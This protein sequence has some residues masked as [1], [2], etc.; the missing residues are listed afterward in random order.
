SRLVPQNFD[1]LYRMAC[2]YYD[3]KMME[4]SGEFYHKA[5]LIKENDPDVLLALG[6][7]EVFK[8]NYSGARKLYD[9]SL[10]KNGDPKII[11]NNLSAVAQ[12]LGFLDLAIEHGNNAVQLDPF[13][14]L[15]LVNLG[16]T[17]CEKREY[18][19]AFENLFKA[20]KLDEKDK[21]I[22]MNLGNLF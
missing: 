15:P 10:K 8:C 3:L 12:T 16:C 13:Y 20:A 7:I 6:N 22:Y 17:Y 5:G 1:P 19:K 14:E 9:E 18:G 2:C 4:K 11:Q 21:Y